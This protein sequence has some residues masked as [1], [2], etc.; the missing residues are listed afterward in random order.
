M[1]SHLRQQYNKNFTQKKYDAFIDEIVSSV[2][3]RPLFHIAETPVFIPNNL[4]DQMLQ[5][6][7][8]MM[9]LICRPDFKQISQDACLPEFYVP[10]E[11]D[12][13]AFLS[14]DF[15][16]CEDEDG[17]LSPQLIEIQGFPSLF[18]Y[19]NICANAYRNHFDIPANFTHH[20]NGLTDEEYYGILKRDIVGSS[21]PENVVL[22][23]IEPHKQNTQIDF[24]A[25]E[26][27]LGIKVLCVSEL[28]TEGK[29]VF[30][31]NENGKKIPVERVYNRVIFDEL[32]KRPDLKREF[33]FQNEYNIKWVG[34]PHWFVRISKH[35]LP[36]FKSKFVPD[37][38]Y[39]NDE[40]LPSDLENYVLK[41]LYSFSGQGVI[42][43]P[44]INDVHAI[45]EDQRG[46][47]ILQKKVKYAPIVKTLDEPAK[48]EVRIMMAWEEGANKP[49]AMT[50]LVRLS[51]GEMV[52]VR[53]NQ[54][55]TWVGG[56]IGFFEKV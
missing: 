11:T 14:V 23:D 48:A 37:S 55:K 51:K 56:S 13:P 2:D 54:G 7:D 4:R 21:H 3:H 50:N 19:Q 47:Y 17:N 41:P 18:F 46:N 1:I 28:K 38:F 35:T 29:D 5:A 44:T 26:R 32:I 36:L 12:H 52:G 20:F 43:Y 53:Y 34:H 22:I 15:G 31:L 16:I 8:E 30:Y 40:K 25:T 10:G 9:E 33:Y 27:K 24:W 6:C 39:L 49:V 42:L 45:P